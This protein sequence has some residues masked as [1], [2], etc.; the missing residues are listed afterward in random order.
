MLSVLG[1]IAGVPFPFV[2]TLSTCSPLT[3][4]EKLPEASGVVVVN[5]PNTLSAPVS[6]VMLPLRKSFC[7]VV[8]DEGYTPSSFVFRSA[9]TALN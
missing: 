8:T 6:R 2:A 7:E 1:V 3:E 5:A 4:I 9:A